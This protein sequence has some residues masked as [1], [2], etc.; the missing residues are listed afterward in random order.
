MMVLMATS[1]S[2]GLLEI[3]LRIYYTDTQ[4]S[5]WSEFHPMRGWA[6]IPG[7]YWVKPLQRLTSFPVTINA[8]GLRDLDAT[9]RA[10]GAARIVVLGDSFTFAKETSTEK[11]FTRQLQDLLDTRMTGVEVMNAGVPGY[12]TSQ[13]LL[14]ERE[15]HDRHGIDAQMYVLMFFTNDILDNLRLSYGNLAPQP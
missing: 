13:E 5:N 7:H 10:R 9:P 6:L 1:V 2:L 12:G 4:S 11:M 14:F 15:L 3:G 8:F